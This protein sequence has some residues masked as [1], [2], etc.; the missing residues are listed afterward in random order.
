MC[1]HCILCSHSS[2]NGHLNTWVSFF[3]LTVVKSAAVNMGLQI[4]SCDPSFSSF[5]YRPR[6]QIVGSYGNFMFS[7]LRNCHTVSIVAT[8]F[9]IPS[10][11]A[12][13]LQFLHTLANTYF[14]FL[15]LF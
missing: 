2:V 14:P 6:S 1:I 8:L 5:G 9:Y 4:S 3:P 15:F 10:N 13:G 12:P 7:S 11:S